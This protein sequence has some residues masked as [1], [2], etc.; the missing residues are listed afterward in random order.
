M[1][2]LT[3][4]QI[5]K[6][7]PYHGKDGRFASA[8]SAA[9]FTFKPGASAAHD[10]AIAR[11]K[12]R[13]AATAAPKK[14]Y[15][16]SKEEQIAAV[17]DFTISDYS[18]IRKVQ[19]G[20]G[21]MAQETQDS[22]RKK[23]EAIEEYIDAS[24]PYEGAVYRGINTDTVLKVGQTVDMQGTSSWSTDKEV[25]V[26]FAGTHANGDKGPWG[27]KTGNEKAYVFQMDKAPRKNTYIDDIS[28]N[29]GEKEV[30]VSKDTRFKITKIEE[31]P[32]RTFVTVEE[33]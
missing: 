25:G 26:D 1:P 30:L 11:E 9:S 18:E 20:Q 27:R 19:C 23:G 7:N 3:F 17:K 12:E 14:E 5:L 13:D 29:R 21:K 28:A 31:T 32:K 8:N 33:V 16:Y 22:L 24:T 2:A 6:F 10:S 15:K 4:D